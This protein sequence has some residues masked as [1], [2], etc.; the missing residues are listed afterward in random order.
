MIPFIMVLDVTS[1]S[2]SLCQLLAQ[3]PPASQ[4]PAGHVHKA[5]GGRLHCFNPSI[6]SFMISDPTI[7]PQAVNPNSPSFLNLL[8]TAH[9]LAFQRKFFSLLCPCRHVWSST[10]EAR[11]GRLRSTKLFFSTTLT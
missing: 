6:K 10:D 8:P 4:L 2:F 9:L 11:G 5:C 7:L 1:Q 3:H